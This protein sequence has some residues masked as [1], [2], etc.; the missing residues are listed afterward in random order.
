MNVSVV[1]DFVS[2][3]V[4]FGVV[5]VGGPGFDSMSPARDINAASHNG[6]FCGRQPQK[7]RFG[8][9]PFREAGKCCRH[10]HPHPPG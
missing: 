6:N 10:L 9:L 8:G 3:V 4:V 2:L 5:R 1:F 7:M